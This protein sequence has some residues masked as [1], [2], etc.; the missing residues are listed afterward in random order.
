MPKYSHVQLN[1]A[2]RPNG[3]G[4]RSSVTRLKVTSKQPATSNQQPA[5]SNQN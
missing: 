5:T 2:W 1:V 4:Y 3:V